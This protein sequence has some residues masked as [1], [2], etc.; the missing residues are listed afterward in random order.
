MMGTLHKSQVRKHNNATCIGATNN[1]KYE[2]LGKF[3]NMK[4]TLVYLKGRPFHPKISALKN[5][6]DEI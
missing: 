1:F 2:I 4:V 6:S 5:G 3:V